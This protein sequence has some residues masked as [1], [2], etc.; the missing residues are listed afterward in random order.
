MEE[1]KVP[2]EDLVVATKIFFGASEK[3]FPNSKFCSRKHIIEGLRN[4]LKRL[5]MTYVDIVFAHRYDHL[6]PMEE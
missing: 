4:S 5:Q 3:D 6:T 1:K 2:R